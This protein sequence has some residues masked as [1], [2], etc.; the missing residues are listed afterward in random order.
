MATCFPSIA[1]LAWGTFHFLWKS[2]AVACH[3]SDVVGREMTSS[4]YT[5]TIAWHTF[6]TR[7]DMVFRATL[8]SY[9]TKVIDICHP[10]LDALWSLPVSILVQVLF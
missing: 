3:S 8:K 5:S 7:R 2:S 10:M 6:G 1:P 9:C 4:L